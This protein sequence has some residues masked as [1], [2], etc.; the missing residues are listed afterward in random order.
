MFFIDSKKFLK[1]ENK[2]FKEVLHLC[3]VN[4]KCKEGWSEREKNHL[5]ATESQEEKK[6]LLQ[7]Q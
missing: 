3:F 1:K 2:L 5:A 7:D 4:T 6:L